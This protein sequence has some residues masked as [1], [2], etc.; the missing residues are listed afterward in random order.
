MKFYLSMLF[1]LLGSQSLPAIDSYQPGDTLYV[2]AASGLTLRKAP[3]LTAAKLALVPYGTLL[4]ALNYFNGHDTRVEA[5]P[6]FMAYNQKIEAVMLGGAFACV[7]FEGD[8]GYVFDGYL[9]KMPALKRRKGKIESEPGFE[10]FDT[11]AKR[12]FGLVAKDQHGTREY[13][14]ASSSRMVYGNGFVVSEWSE[15]DA[16]GRM[17]LPDISQEEAFL[18]FNYIYGYEHDIRRDAKGQPC[19]NFEECWAFTAVS[20]FEWMFGEGLCGYKILYLPE[21]KIAIITTEC[22]C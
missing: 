16:R 6:G 8:T 11:W 21:E 22:S 13:G 1:L 12:N 4:V 15:K 3:A 2:W 20:K 19:A 5:V 14:T 7:V 10:N 17:I 18:L 9:S